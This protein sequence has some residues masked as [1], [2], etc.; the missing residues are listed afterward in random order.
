MPA[1][2]HGEHRDRRVP[3]HHQH[4][5]HA[6]HSVTR[7]TRTVQHLQDVTPSPLPPPPCPQRAHHA[8]CYDSDGRESG[9]TVKA[10]HYIVLTAIAGKFVGTPE[11]GR[12]ETEGHGQEQKTRWLVQAGAAQNPQKSSLVLFRN[13]SAGSTDCFRDNTT[14]EERFRVPPKIAWKNCY[15]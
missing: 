8:T 12:G 13:R 2:P 5:P 11:R 10:G 3:T 6:A 14:M 15:S 7:R 1:V 9:H 4:R